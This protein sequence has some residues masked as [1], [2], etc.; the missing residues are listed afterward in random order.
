MF[1]SASPH[2]FCSPSLPG[3]W[4]VRS[5]LLSEYNPSEIS[6]SPSSDA[7]WESTVNCSPTFAVLPL[8]SAMVSDTFSAVVLSVVQKES[9]EE[10]VAEGLADAV[11]G[12]VEGVGFSGTV[13]HPARTVNV[14]AASM[15]VLF[16]RVGYLNL[17]CV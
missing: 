2:R 14:A 17:W 6:G 15:V 16:I 7:V 12:G 8:S 11:S 13:V 1:V 5:A 3:V 10:I 4:G 9:T